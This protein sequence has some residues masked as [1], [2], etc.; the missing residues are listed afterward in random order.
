MKQAIKTLITT[1]PSKHIRISPHRKT[2]HYEDSSNI[3]NKRGSGNFNYETSVSSQPSHNGN[4]APLAYQVLQANNNQTNCNNS[5]TQSNQNIATIIQQRMITSMQ[6]KSSLK[7]QFLTKNQKDS[8][9]KQKTTDRESRQQTSTNSKKQSN[10]NLGRVLPNYD[11][12]NQDLMFT[13]PITL[14]R[15][16]PSLGYTQSVL[17]NDSDSKQIIKNFSTAQK[18]KKKSQ[19]MT[20]GRGSASTLNSGKKRN[21]ESISNSRQ[22]KNNKVTVISLF[23]S[24]QL[25][26]NQAQKTLKPSANS[27]QHLLQSP[28]YANDLEDLQDREVSKPRNNGASQQMIVLNSPGGSSKSRKG[29]QSIMFSPPVNKIVTSNPFDKLKKVQSSNS[30]KYHQKF[31]TSNIVSPKSSN[32]KND[33]SKQSNMRGFAGES[34]QSIMLRNKSK[35]SNRVPEIQ[36]VISP[37]K[38]KVIRDGKHTNAN[39]SIANDGSYTRINNSI[40]SKASN[41]SSVNMRPSSPNLLIN[42]EDQ[43]LQQQHFTSLIEQAK[44]TT[45]SNGTQSERDLNRVSYQD[46]FMA[47]YATT[48]NRLTNLKGNSSQIQLLAS[49]NDRQKPNCQSSLSTY[50][51]KS[52]QVFEIKNYTNEPQSF[53]KKSQEIQV[54]FPYNKCFNC[55]E[56]ELNGVNS[57]KNSFA[58]KL[59]SPHS[60]FK[61]IKTINLQLGYQDDSLQLNSKVITI[62]L[63]QIKSRCVNPVMNLRKSVEALA[64]ANFAKSMDA[65]DQI[66]LNESRIDEN[67]IQSALL[68]LQLYPQQSMYDNEK[69]IAL[70]KYEELLRKIVVQYTKLQRQFYD[71]QNRATQSDQHIA[72]LN[73][74]QQL[75]IQN[76]LQE[77]KNLQQ[78]V[79]NE[80]NQRVME[81]QTFEKLKQGLL[82]EI[83]RLQDSDVTYR[84][85]LQTY[86]D[87]RQT[88][89][90]AV[91]SLREQILKAETENHSLLNENKRLKTYTDQQEQELSRIKQ[92][93]QILDKKSQENKYLLDQS[94]ATNQKIEQHYQQVLNEN[95]Q[96]KKAV[97][98]LQ[99]NLQQLM[100]ANVKYKEEISHLMIEKQQISLKLLSYQQQLNPQNNQSQMSHFTHSFAQDLEYGFP[101]SAIPKAE[102]DLLAKTPTKVKNYQQQNVNN[103][104]SL[105]GMGNMSK[106]NSSDYK[107]L[108]QKHFETQKNQS[109]LYQPNQNNRVSQLTHNSGFYTPNSNLNNSNTF[110]SCLAGHT[111]NK[112]R[113]TSKSIERKYIAN[114]SSSVNKIMSWSEAQHAQNLRT[115]KSTSC[116]KYEMSQTKPNRLTSDFLQSNDF[117]YLPAAGKDSKQLHSKEHKHFNSLTQ[118]QEVNQIQMGSIKQYLDMDIREINPD[119]L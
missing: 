98:G 55:Y 115:P 43:F 61:E 70:N 113:I 6:R 69:N 114:D 37:D 78:I 116:Q 89:E 95:Q 27:Q 92:T 81:K 60:S 71:L 18:I 108:E 111:P 26:K 82:T 57:T 54:Q 35:E 21:L 80:M 72:G 119:Q 64:R 29:S 112:E 34:S 3:S 14:D 66:M 101:L 104:S 2:P 77:N 73:Q 13:I 67:E 50:S 76:L 74:D 28:D 38:S 58:S 56:N 53:G 51:Q 109:L 94:Q 9:K 11:E 105:F 93:N 22:S 25:P 52:N 90:K 5:S 15:M 24:Q 96:I 97:D 65:L 20:V 110:Q 85:K 118:S 62:N 7:T 88:L 32:K 1:V 117:D 91:K 79:A 45:R 12:N 33:Q 19:D 46:P 103:N 30:T 86:S 75:Q 107:S 106:Q 68:N 4:L 84:Q 83:K 59:N 40:I 48:N 87:D 49:S 39:N 100:D 42:V 102:I 44:L 63:Q 23:A 17:G 99:G 41:Y 36:L 16:T 8:S 47:Q 31:L 10:Q